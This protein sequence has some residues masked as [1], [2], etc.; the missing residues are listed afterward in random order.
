MDPCCILHRS[1]PPS[2]V[3]VPLTSVYLVPDGKVG[4]DAFVVI[5]ETIRSMDMVAIGRVVLPKISVFKQHQRLA[6]SVA[7]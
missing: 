5:R 6:S 1:E 7:S 3:A 4:H 2:T